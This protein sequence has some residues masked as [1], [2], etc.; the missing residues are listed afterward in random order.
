MTKPFLVRLEQEDDVFIAVRNMR[1]MIREQ[2]SEADQQA[3]LVSVLEL[4]RNVIHHAGSRGI[5]YCEWLG[6]GVRIQVKDNGPG[7]RDLERILASGYRSPN[8]LG[9]GL[10]AVQRLMDD[11]QIQTSERGTDIIAIKR[12]PSHRRQ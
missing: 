2:F 1:L 11:M 5:F 9:L 3:I 10:Q 8:G 4:T 7:I 6:D 12:R